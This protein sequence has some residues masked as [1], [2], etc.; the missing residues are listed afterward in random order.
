[1]YFE[2]YFPAKPKPKVESLA[3][4]LRAAYSRRI[5]RLSWMSAATKQ[6][7]L[8]KLA[9]YSVKV[10]FPDHPR[11]YA[12][13]EIRRDDLVGDVRRAAAAEWKRLVQR[14]GGPVDWSELISTPEVND[15]YNGYLND[16]VF[17]A[18]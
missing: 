5:E 11:D 18:A 13:V 3:A 15:A 4:E 14:S 8:K 10:G 7:A 2:H 16:V 17:A 1:M 9:A 12:S 6:E